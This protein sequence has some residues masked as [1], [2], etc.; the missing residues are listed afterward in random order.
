M[1]NPAPLQKGGSQ[2]PRSE[3]KGEQTAPKHHIKTKVAKYRIP[4]QNPHRS[5][6]IRVLLTALRAVIIFF[7]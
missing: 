2:V 1:P 5:L 4:N 3:E 7:I 6:I